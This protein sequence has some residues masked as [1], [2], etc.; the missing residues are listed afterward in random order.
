MPF[1]EAEVIS[2]GLVDGSPAALT[3]IRKKIE[4]VKQE[5]TIVHE[6]RYRCNTRAGYAQGK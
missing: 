6:G 1:G 5:S 2:V 3:G 4:K